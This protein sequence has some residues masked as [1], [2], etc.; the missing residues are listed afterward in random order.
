VFVVEKMR[1][2]M[3]T[4]KQEALPAIASVARLRIGEYLMI[5]WED[6]SLTIRR[7]EDRY[8]DNPPVFACDAENIP[9]FARFLSPL[10]A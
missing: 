9:Q 10:G 8:T 3:P 5:I 4:E 7:W 1:Y 2:K 6:R